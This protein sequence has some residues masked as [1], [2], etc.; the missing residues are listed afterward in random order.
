MRRNNYTCKRDAGISTD[1]HLKPVYQIH[2]LSVCECV[3][4][5]CLFVCVTL[6]KLF[7]LHYVSCLCY[8]M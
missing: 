8:I 6:C 2:N 7:V 4:F 1:S 5:A 3:D